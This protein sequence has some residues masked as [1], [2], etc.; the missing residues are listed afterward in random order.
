MIKNKVFGANGV[1]KN[2][3]E[4]NENLENLGSRRTPFWAA[5]WISK[6]WFFL[7]K[8]NVFGANGV[9]EN[10]FEKKQKGSPEPG[11][12]LLPSVAPEGT[13]PAMPVR[14]SKRPERG[15]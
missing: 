1:P 10:E 5:K 7:A 2:E 6:C 13:P 11:P 3:P 14:D 12:I 4:N 15:E 9:P 8:N